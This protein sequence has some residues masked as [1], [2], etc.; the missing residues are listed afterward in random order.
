MSNVIPRLQQVGGAGLLLYGSSAVVASRFMDLQTDMGW[1]GQVTGFVGSGLALLL[2]PW[3]RRRFFDAKDSARLQDEL[4]ELDKSMVNKPTGNTGSCNCV[5]CNCVN[6]NCACQLPSEALK[7]IEAIHRLAS[8]MR[9][10]EEGT[11]L[12]RSLQNCL[13]DLHHAEDLASDKDSAE[14]SDDSGTE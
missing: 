5:N 9:G 1:W 8:R 13:F 12:C 4:N 10:H 14:D 3:L 6:C 2:W 11:E 7:D